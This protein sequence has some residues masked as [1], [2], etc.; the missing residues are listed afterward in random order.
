MRTHVS[1]WPRFRWCRGEKSWQTWVVRG[2]DLESGKRRSPRF[3]AFRRD[4]CARE[5]ARTG[6][7]PERPGPSFCPEVTELLDNSEFKAVV[8]LLIKPGLQI[9]SVLMSRNP[10]RS[11]FKE[12]YLFSPVSCLRLFQCLVYLGSTT[13]LVRFVGLRGD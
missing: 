13:L 2:R 9:F 7:S 8:F 10:Q 5:P 3:R 6:S 1:A 12:C 4:N 11:Q